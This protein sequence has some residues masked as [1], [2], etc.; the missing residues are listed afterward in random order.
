MCIRDSS[1]AFW[2]TTRWN[3]SQGSNSEFYLKIVYDE[4]VATKEDVDEWLRE[5]YPLKY[6]FSYKSAM[7]PMLF[8]KFVTEHFREARKISRAVSD[9]PWSKCVDV[10][11][12]YP[13]RK[14]QRFSEIRIEEMIAKAGLE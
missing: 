12:S 10:L 4:Q 1:D 5:T 6:W 8:A 9:A 2:F 14:F 13:V 7:E 11:L 3:L